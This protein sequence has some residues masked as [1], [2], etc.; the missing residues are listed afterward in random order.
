MNTIQC[1]HCCRRVD[2][3][4]VGRDYLCA[5]CHALTVL[6]PAGEVNRR[7]RGHDFLTSTLIRTIPALYATENV[8]IKDKVIHAHYFVGGCDWYIAEL[9]RETGDAFGYCDVGQGYAEWGYSNLVEMERTL[10][11]ELLPIERDLDF[12]PT[13]ARELGIA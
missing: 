7:R 12:T 1:R 11:F 5:A 3:A 10:A 8:P 9:D 2:S 13:T 6:F 4:E